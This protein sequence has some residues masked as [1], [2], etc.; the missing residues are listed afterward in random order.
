VAKFGDLFTVPRELLGD[1]YIMPIEIYGEG[2]LVRC[3][4]QASSKLNDRQLCKS[5]FT[6]SARTLYNE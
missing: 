4:S 1:I 6:S 2:V 3:L 5:V